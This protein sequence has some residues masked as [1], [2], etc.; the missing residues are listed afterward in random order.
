MRFTYED[1]YLRLPASTTL[2]VLHLDKK[3]NHRLTAANWATYIYDFRKQ[4]YQDL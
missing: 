2:K 1:G 4:N 3:E